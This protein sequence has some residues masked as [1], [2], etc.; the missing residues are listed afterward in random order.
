MRLRYWL[1]CFALIASGFAAKELWLGFQRMQREA[2]RRQKQEMFAQLRSVFNLPKEAVVVRGYVHDTW[3][4]G[5]RWMVTF[6][7]PQ[8][9][10]PEQW[11]RELKGLAF[12]RAKGTRKT[13]L[14]LEGGG[15]YWRIEYL[16]A[17]GEYAMELV[18][19]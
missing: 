10:R 13:R 2:K 15:D 11:V 9:R 14:K 19:D 5:G 17:F 7:L 4:V 3:F 6:S 8:T 12:P 16:P 18:V 1:L